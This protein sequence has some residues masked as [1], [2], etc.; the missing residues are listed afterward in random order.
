MIENINVGLTAND[1]LGDKL[2][3]A[4]IIVNENFD[5][6]DVILTG[7]GTLTISQIA[8]LQTALDNINTQ[9]AY[10]PGLQSDINSINNTLYTINQTLNS[11]NSSISDLYLNITNL[12][13]QIYNKIEEAPIDGI[14]YGRKDGN[15]EII[16]ITPTIPTIDEVLGAGNT[17]V[18]KELHINNVGETV[19][20]TI[21]PSYINLV[22]GSNNN[23]LLSNS[24]VIDDSNSGLMGALYPNRLE[25]KDI[26]VQYLKANPSQSPFYIPTFYFPAKTLTGS[27]TLATTLD[28]TV[29]T[30]VSGNTNN[31]NIISSGTTRTLYARGLTSSNNTISISGTGSSASST[32]GWDI[33]SNITKTSDLINDGDDGVSHF[34]SNLDLP[35]NLILYATT[36]TSS[37]SGYYKLVTD[38]H[39][40]AFNTTAVDVSTGVITTTSQLISN[41][42]TNAGIINGNPGIFNITTIGNITKVSGSGEAEFYFDVYKR[43]SLGVETFITQSSNTLPVTNTGYTEF[44]A[45]ALWND[46]L[47]TLTDKIVLKFYANRIAGGSNP[48][49]QFQ[50]GG[51]SPVRSLVPIPLYAVP[52]GALDSLSDV[53]ITS[54]IEGDIL[55]YNQSSDTWTNKSIPNVLG[56][57]PID[58]ETSIV[59]AIIFG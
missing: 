54:A 47:F 46:G 36:A 21:T 20:T 49:Y 39:D 59:N 32:Y 8:G 55:A 22:N 30:V 40:P 42:V 15:W 57:T 4:F 34:I 27:Y 58:N 29:A 25:L 41:L 14:T 31:L 7:T 13:N 17:A 2:R 19:N 45:T 6:I 35:S 24:I 28:I 56:F 5:A 50:F 53:T 1:G 26:G 3:D 52:G 18:D 23:T 37:V 44:S 51:I 38:I 10:I 33:K 43:D 16:S 11:Q 48:T 12:Q 9:I